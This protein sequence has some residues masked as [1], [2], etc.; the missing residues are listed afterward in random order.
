MKKEFLSEYS[1]GNVECFHVKFEQALEQHRR[2]LLRKK[3]QE[4]FFKNTVDTINNEL[5]T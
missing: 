5:N 1:P 2:E 4:M 3:E